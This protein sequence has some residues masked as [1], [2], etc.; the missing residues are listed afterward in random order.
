MASRYSK[1]QSTLF[2]SEKFRKLNDFQ[3]NVYV[4]LLI[5]PHGNSAGFYKLN[6]GYAAVDLDC[7]M[8]RYKCIT[9]NKKVLNL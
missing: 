8:Q 7:T 1:V 2:N 9:S 5:S 4:Y 3:K 6:E